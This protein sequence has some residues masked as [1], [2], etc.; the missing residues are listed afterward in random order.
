MNEGVQLATGQLK[1]RKEEFIWLII[2]VGRK[3]DYAPQITAGP[4]GFKKL[5][6]HLWSLLFATWFLN[7]CKNISP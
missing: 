3:A 6:L 1:E 5:S 2:G 7:I 4:P